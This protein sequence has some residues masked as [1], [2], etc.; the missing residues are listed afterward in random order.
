MRWSGPLGVYSA[1]PSPVLID[2]TTTSPVSTLTGTRRLT[3][4]FGVQL[5]DVA[6]NLIVHPEC[7]VERTPSVVFVGDRRAEQRKDAVARGVNEIAVVAV[8]RSSI[9]SSSAGS[10]MARASGYT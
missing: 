6:L 1:W 9:I 3:P 7:R 4:F 2:R 5:F 10:T 8:A